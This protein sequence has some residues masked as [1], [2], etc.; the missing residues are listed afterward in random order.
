M[1]RQLAVLE[2]ELTQID[3]KPCSHFALSVQ[4]G[5]ETSTRFKP[6]IKINYPRLI[7]PLPFAC[8][9]RTTLDLNGRRPHNSNFPL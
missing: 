2:L 6:P 4:K 7:F 3:R 1:K 5:F 8:R 9:R